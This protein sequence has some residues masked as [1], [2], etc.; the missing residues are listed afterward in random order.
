MHVVM[1]SCRPFMISRSYRSGCHAISG[2]GCH[3]GRSVDQI[4]LILCSNWWHGT[5][6]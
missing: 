4:A 1:E 6:A 3:L 5:I 2:F